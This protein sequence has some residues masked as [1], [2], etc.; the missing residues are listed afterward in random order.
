LKRNLSSPLLCKQHFTAE[1]TVLRWEKRMTSPIYY[2]NCCFP[3]N[4]PI[5]MVES[6]V[7]TAEVKKIARAKKLKLL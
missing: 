2:I 4:L 7:T 3:V 5:A 6:E 1:S